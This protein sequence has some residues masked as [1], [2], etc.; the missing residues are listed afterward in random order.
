M[1]TK[2]A[3]EIIRFLVKKENFRKKFT[4][5]YISN[6]LSRISYRKVSELLPMFALKFS[7]IFGYEQY[8]R[9]EYF[10][11]NCNREDFEKWFKDW[12]CKEFEYV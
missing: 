5:N 6:S 8:I 7:D 2:E 11:I 4:V 12:F 1:K 10:W 3:E 9:T